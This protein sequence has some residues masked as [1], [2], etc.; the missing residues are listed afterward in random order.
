MGVNFD[1]DAAS[2]LVYVLSHDKADWDRAVEAYITAATDGM[3]AQAIPQTAMHCAPLL[4]MF[5][6]MRRPPP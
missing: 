2:R 6:R 3:A 4:A 1:N 5:D